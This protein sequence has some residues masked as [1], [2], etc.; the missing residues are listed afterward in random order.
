MLPK[1]ASIMDKGRLLRPYD[2][3]SSNDI[4]LMKT[5]LKNGADINK[6]G[7]P[8]LCLA[9]QEGFTGI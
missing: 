5:L 6:G 4:T 3:V 1:L 8:P 2:A 9:T 7:D